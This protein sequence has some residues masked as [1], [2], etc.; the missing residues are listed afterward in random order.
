MVIKRKT[1]FAT[2]A[3]FL[4]LMTITFALASQLNRQN[5]YFKNLPNIIGQRHQLEFKRGIK[6]K[7]LNSKRDFNQIET[8]DGFN[9]VKLPSQ[10][11]FNLSQIINGEGS[12]NLYFDTNL[13]IPAA[14]VI[15]GC[16]NGTTNLADIKFILRSFVTERKSIPIMAF[17]PYSKLNSDILLD[18]SRCIRIS[19]KISKTNLTFT[20]PR[21]LSLIFNIEFSK[22]ALVS[23]LIR[24]NE[25]NNFGELISF[26]KKNNYDYRSGLKWYDFS[27]GTEQISRSIALEKNGDIFYMADVFDLGDKSEVLTW[28]DLQWLPGS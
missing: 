8:K 11:L 17:E 9:L 4:I 13:I 27:F 23:E 20:P 6:E 24:K 21:V 3:I 14:D 10:G 1:A 25:I 28:S 19:P 15:K 18:L 22:A 5:S 16:S 7:F 12:Q 2:A 26:F